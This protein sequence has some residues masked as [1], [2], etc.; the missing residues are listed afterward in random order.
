MIYSQDLYMWCHWGSSPKWYYG[1]APK[2]EWSYF[3]NALHNLPSEEKIVYLIRHHEISNTSR[4]L[5]V[6]IKRYN[7]LLQS[8][9]TNRNNALAEKKDDYTELETTYQKDIESLQKKYNMRLFEVLILVF[10]DFSAG[11]FHAVLRLKEGRKRGIY[12]VFMAKLK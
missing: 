9:L 5:W 2:H 8:P 12:D 6:Y 3:Y 4:Q 11:L 7:G 1:E 10:C